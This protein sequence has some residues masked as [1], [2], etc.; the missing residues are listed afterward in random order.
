MLRS[1]GSYSRKC[2][3]LVW[4]NKTNDSFNK[5]NYCKGQH[6]A[7]TMRRNGNY[8][9]Q[10]REKQY[11]RYHYGLM[12][13]QF[14]IIVSRA[15]NMSGNMID[16]LANLLESRLDVIVYRANFA[17]TIFAA[18]QFV[19]HGKILVNGKR[20]N[21][22]G[23]LVKNGD[24]AEIV[25]SFRKNDKLLESIEKTERS[26]PDYLTVDKDKFSVVK[27]RENSFSEVTFG[28][29]IRIGLVVEYYSKKL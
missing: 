15:K 22:C 28:S 7:T 20:V 5:K 2:K 27:I 9:V 25:E 10:L 21:L 4:E 8:A 14:S 13:K 18:K 17:S 16:N 12:E 1:V 29:K 3:R 11:V 23:Y 26:V 19:S 6:G 24:V